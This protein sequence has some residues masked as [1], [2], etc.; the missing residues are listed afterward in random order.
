MWSQLIFRCAYTRHSAA[1]DFRRT[2]VTFDFPECINRL[3]TLCRENCRESHFGRSDGCPP[4]RSSAGRY[5]APLTIWLIG[6]SGNVVQKNKMVPS[7]DIDRCRVTHRIRVG[8][9]PSTFQV[10]PSLAE[11]VPTLA[12]ATI[13]PHCPYCPHCVPFCPFCPFGAPLGRCAIEKTVRS[14]G[15]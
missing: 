11:T 1:V 7:C 10:N 13:C 2:Y 15:R 4:P 9:P 12:L 14:T 5:V 6:F 8:F 3:T